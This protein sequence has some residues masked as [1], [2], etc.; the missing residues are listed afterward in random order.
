M[1]EESESEHHMEGLEKVC[2]VKME[3]MGKVS[4][5]TYNR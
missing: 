1:L 3:N 2:S 4:G 5:F